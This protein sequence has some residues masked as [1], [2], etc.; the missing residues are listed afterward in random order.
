VLIRKVSVFLHATF[1]TQDRWA[2]L[3]PNEQ[4]TDI[5]FFSIHNWLQ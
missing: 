2:Q 4:T 3:K 5:I 1:H